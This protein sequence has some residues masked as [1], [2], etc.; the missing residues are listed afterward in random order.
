M[1]I[2]EGNTTSMMN[3]GNIY[4]D[5][6]NEGKSIEYYIMASEHGNED[7]KK[8]LENYYN[9]KDDEEFVKQL[10]NEYHNQNI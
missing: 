5:C 3:L 2:K 4:K 1:A 7:A 10:Q 9:T 8:Y 6:Q